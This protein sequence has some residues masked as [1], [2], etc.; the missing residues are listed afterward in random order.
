MT[1][2]ELVRH[3]ARRR[4]QRHR[5]AGPRAQ[6]RRRGRRGQRG[7]RR[8]GHRLKI[9]VKAVGPN[10]FGTGVEGHR[11]DGRPGPGHRRR[12][13]AT[14]AAASPGPACR[15]RREARPAGHRQQ[16][17]RRP[18]CSPPR[19]QRARRGRFSGGQGP[20]PPRPR[21]RARGAPG[22]QRRPPGGRAVRGQRRP[23]VHLHRRRHPRHVGQGGGAAVGPRRGP[24]PSRRRPPP[25]GR[26]RPIS[27]PA[28]PGRCHPRAATREWSSRCSAP[29]PRSA[30][31]ASACSPPPRP[32]PD[33]CPP[34]TRP[35]RRGATMH[36]PA[37]GGTTMT[38]EPS[39]APG[40]P[41]RH[42]GGPAHGPRPPLERGAVGPGRP[43]RG[44]RDHRPRLRPPRRRR[45]LPRPRPR[46]RQAHREAC[47]GRCS[48]TCGSRSRTWWPRATGW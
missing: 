46:R 44:R 13:V 45:P 26:T 4:H 8:E 42:P 24:P 6:R 20:H 43:G 29:A 33:R 7:H 10:S 36:P 5:R 17:Q 37:R 35:R 28:A 34:P 30:C 15:V 9:A 12:L 18:A 39:P 40:P 31:W 23:A 48:P 19:Q 21:G 27:G 32:S 2:A 16:R 11:R 25:A 38:T 22:G 3:H 41:P 1:P 47:C 14:S